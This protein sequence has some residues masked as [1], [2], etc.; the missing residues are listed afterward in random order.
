MKS[1]ANGGIGARESRFRSSRAIVFVHTVLD[2]YVNLDILRTP[3]VVWILRNTCGPLPIHDCQIDSLKIMLNRP[4]ATTVVSYLTEG[5][6][7][8]VV[9]GPFAGCVGMLI[10]Q[11]PRKGRLVVS[12]DIIRQSASVELDVEDVEPIPPPGQFL[13][14][15]PSR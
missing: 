11:D 3:G 7:V 8:Q 2:N 9:R 4:Q 15:I 5:D 10:R 1:G 6:W 13:S 14:Q 12:I